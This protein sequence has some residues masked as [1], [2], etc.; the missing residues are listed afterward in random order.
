MY[1]ITH[2]S[3]DNKRTSY[4]DIATMQEAFDL[5][6]KLEEA[7]SKSGEMALLFNGPSLVMSAKFETKAFT[8]CQYCGRA[9]DMP[10]MECLSDDCPS[11]YEEKGAAY[12]GRAD[13]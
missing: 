10:V 9:Y 12:P 7:M 5:F 8:E 1:S 2:Y 3:A 4:P 13:E 6:R 11:H